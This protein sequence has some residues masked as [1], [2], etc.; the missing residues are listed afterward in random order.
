MEK[1]ENLKEYAKDNNVPIMQDEGIDFLCKY[2]TEHGIETILECGTAI[3]YSAIKMASQSSKIRVDTCEIKEELV[4]IARRNIAEKGLES[5]IS[6]Y[7]G[8]AAIFET[9]EKY[10]LIFVDAAKAQYQKYM[11]HFLGN[12]KEGGC[13]V[14]DN[15]EF[16]G[17]V[18]DIES[19]KS[20]N[21]RQLVKK[22]KKF[23]EDLFSC[24]NIE[25]QYFPEIGDGI[26]VVKIK[27]R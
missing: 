9:A 6:V 25:T 17:L 27:K 2:I 13:F 15:L 10:D 16:H 5:Q 11:D 21:T 4:E 14:F 3:G 26:A 8:D 22:I 24:P 18:N 19:I 7:C 1:I 12:L 23:K 20:R